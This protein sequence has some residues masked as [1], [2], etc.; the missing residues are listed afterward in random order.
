MLM[1]ILI[2]VMALIIISMLTISVI[3]LIIGIIWLVKSL[4][5]YPI[6]RYKVKMT[7]YILEMIKQKY[8]SQD[9]YC[10]L[11][12]RPTTFSHWIPVYI[13]IIG[14]VIYYETTLNDRTQLLELNNVKYISDIYGYYYH[15]VKLI[16]KELL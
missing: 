12:V 8:I 4:L 7:P 16:K 6:T 5:A 15:N 3:L 11:Y 2:F 10:A 14:G 1:N 9:N 13:N